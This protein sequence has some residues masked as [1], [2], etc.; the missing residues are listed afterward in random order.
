[1]ANFLLPDLNLIDASTVRLYGD[2]DGSYRI[3]SVLVSLTPWFNK[4]V[5]LD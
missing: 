1:M 4:A 2:D 3:V 5:V